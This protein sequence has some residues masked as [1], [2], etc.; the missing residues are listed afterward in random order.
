MPMS[1]VMVMLYF[2][3]THKVAVR[4][5]NRDQRSSGTYGMAIEMLHPPTGAAHLDLG[6]VHVPIEVVYE[7]VEGYEG[8]CGAG[9]DGIVR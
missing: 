5:S 9:G 2:L 3:S 7:T 4:R 6:P 8:Q 1:M